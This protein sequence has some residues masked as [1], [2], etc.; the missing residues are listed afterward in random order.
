MSIDD[1]DPNGHVLFKTFGLQQAQRHGIIDQMLR[2]SPAVRPTAAAQL[3]LMAYQTDYGI[4]DHIHNPD[5]NRPLAIMAL[6]PKEN[7]WEGGPM[8]SLI[9]RYHTYRIY[10]QGYSWDVFCELPYPHAMFVIEMAEDAIRQ[11]DTA[12]DKAQRELDKQM[13]G[14]KH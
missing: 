13:Q 8:F 5:P 12:A 11:R 10:E 14:D 7:S 1:D 3:S 2:D 9:R 6:H 4:Y